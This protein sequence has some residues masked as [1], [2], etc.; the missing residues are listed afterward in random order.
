MVRPELT[1]L[2]SLVCAPMWAACPPVT[3]EQLQTQDMA[4][5]TYLSESGTAG[6]SCQKQFPYRSQA[7]KEYAD[8]LW[9]QIL[10]CEPGKQIAKDQQVSHPDS[11]ELLQYKTASELYAVSVKDK[12]ALNATYVFVRI[13]PYAKTN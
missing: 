2:F 6:F 8:I 1:I 5:S 10:I 12:G 7:A 9:T 4:C 11:Y 13:E 3:L